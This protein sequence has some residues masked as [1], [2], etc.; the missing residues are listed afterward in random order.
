MSHGI[1]R[2]RGTDYLRLFDD[3]TDDDRAVWER[4]RR[5]VDDEV[6]PVINDYWEKAE[7]PWEL[8]RRM[9]ELGILGG[10]V[11]G[12]G[13][14][15]LSPVAD[16]LVA[17]ELNRGDGSV[18]TFNGV[19]SGLV[20]RTIAML[21]SEEQ[22]SHWL[23]RLATVEKIGAFGLTEPEHGSDSVSLST[24]ARRDGDEWVLNGAKKWIGNGSI[25]DVTIIWARDEADDEVKGFLVDTTL[26]GYTAEAMTGKG[27]MRAIWQAE[28]TLRD[29]RVREA[30]RLP[31][32]GSFKDTAAVLAKTRG[33]VAWSALGHALAAFEVVHAYIEERE[34]FGH[35]LAEFQV[36]QHKLANLLADLTAM[37]LY[38]RRLG[39]LAEDDELEETMASLAK[40]HNTTK[41]RQII[42]TARDMMGGNG[43]LLEYHVIRHML[44]IEAIHTYEGTETIQAL[45]VARDLTG[46][47]AFT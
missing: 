14:P 22:K 13:A 34:Q 16:G 18:A 38:C 6:L 8:F 21:G 30:D 26:D 24:S 32:A 4:T 43:V 40:M 27:V 20:M 17:M 10:T 42:S 35:K 5:F 41:A 31:S 25:S 47:S 44:D 11:A 45:L 12:Y 39:Q 7:L 36:I 23:P 37:Q 46:E 3:L 1:G 9:G 15:G 29:V 33:G 28:I 19:Q 2:S